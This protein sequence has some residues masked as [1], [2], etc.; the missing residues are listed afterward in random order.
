MIKK[1]LNLVMTLVL[2]LLLSVVLG[3]NYKVN[4][5]EIEMEPLVTSNGTFVYYKNTT[6]NVMLPKEYDY[7]TYMRSVWVTPLAGCIPSY[8]NADS[9]KK[10]II[11]V[12]DVMDHF[13]LNSLIFHIRIMND[14]LYP[15]KLNPTSNYLNANWDVLEWIIE[16]CHKRGFEFHAWMNPYRVKASGGSTAVEEAAKIKSRCAANIGSNPDNLLVSTSG[17]V[18]LNPGL[19]CVRQFIVDTCMEVIENYDIDA[20]HFDDYFYISNVDDSKTYK[21]NNPNGLGLSDWRREQVNLFIELLHDTMKEYNKANNRYVQLGISPTGI[22]RNGDGVVTYDENGNAISSGSK[23]GGQE[24]YES[25]LFSDTVKWIN[26]EWIDYIMPQSY[27]AFTHTIAGYGDV[28]SWWNKIVKYKNVNLYSGMGIYMSENPGSNYS[29]GYDPYESYNQILYA[30]TLDNCDGTVFYNYTYLE[31]TY[32]GEVGNL[33]NTGLNAVKKDLFNNKCVLPV[34]KN[35]EPVSVKAPTN[36]VID[37]TDKDVSITFNT[38][39]NAKFY[40][41]YRSEGEITFDSSEV[42]DIIYP[43]DKG[44]TKLLWTDKTNGKKYNYAIRTQSPTNH[45]SDDALKITLLKF[46]VV[47]KDLNGN[48]LKTDVVNYGDKAV[49][50]TLQDTTN[51][52][53]WSK[54]IDFVTNDIEVTPR[55]K[56]SDFFVNFYNENGDLIETK[57]TKYQGSVTGPDYQREGFNLVGWSDSLENVVYDLDVY[58]IFEEKTCVVKFVDWDG[59]ELLSIEVKYGRAGYYPEDP[60]RRSYNFTGWSEDVSI[61]KG[62]M[63]VEAQYDPIYFTVTFISDIDD[64]VITTTQVLMHSDVTFPEAPVVPGYVFLNWRGNNTNIITD[65][66]IRAVYNERSY[67]IT[68]ADEFGNVIKEVEYFIG[69][70]IEYPEAPILEDYEFV[71]WE[72]SLDNIVD[73]LTIVAK[74][75]S[76]KLLTITYM[77]NGDIVGFEEVLYGED[78]KFDLEIPTISGKTFD[79]F[80]HD[81]KGITEDITINL[82]YNSNSGCNKAMSLVR[83]TLALTF[84]LVLSFVFRRK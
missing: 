28:M 40:V 25:Y 42:Y 27:W 62:D 35:M 2:V 30:S 9:Y 39:E 22:Y 17:G 12:F 77:Y 56:D 70:N 37:E 55:Y 48:V 75:K 72:G 84:V 47:F 57:K 8:K 16:E 11:E 38:A 71:G 31:R 65:T 60:T 79:K 13:N 61:V 54:N 7:D 3:N 14:A 19:Q 44:T 23:T 4:A 46:N 53:G 20:I 64:S 83:F 43:G 82:L 5:D 41:I 76:T 36:A 29:W 67:M 51:F 50:P 66:T 26:E 74:Y 81:G 63:I 21:A 34:I 33:Y 18:I 73:D 58:P 1:S 45:L 59:T 68:F 78:A 6:E 15:S 10:E 69:D 24:H 80:D 52:V 49:A 32:K